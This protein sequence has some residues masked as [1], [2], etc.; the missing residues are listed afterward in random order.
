MPHHCEMTIDSS[1]IDEITEFIERNRDRLSECPVFTARLTAL[2]RNPTRAFIFLPAKQGL[3]MEP[4]MEL[5]NMVA[6][7]Q[8]GGCE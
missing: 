5:I 4:S 1:D 7:M 8:R 3:K 6:A 2:I